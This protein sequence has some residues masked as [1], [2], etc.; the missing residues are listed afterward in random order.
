MPVIRT[1]AT[2]AAGS[3]ATT[4]AGTRRG[5]PPPSLKLVFDWPRLKRWISTWSAAALW[6]TWAAV[7]IRVSL[8][9]EARIVPLPRLVPLRIWTVG[10]ITAAAVAFSSGRAALG[11]RSTMPK[12]STRDRRRQG[13][14]LDQI[15]VATAQGPFT[16]VIGSWP[17][18]L[19]RSIVGMGTS[20]GRPQELLQPVQAKSAG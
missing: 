19:L 18:W 3:A 8:G 1:T 10:R 20:V 17:S 5:Q 12:A 4:V 16:S 2:S 9:T 13:R 15:T 14:S 6:T 11:S 7:K